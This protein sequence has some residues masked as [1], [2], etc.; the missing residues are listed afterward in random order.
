M[1]IEANISKG[2]TMTKP[3]HQAPTQRGSFGEICGSI[4]KSAYN[5][6]QNEPKINPIAGPSI[7]TPIVMAKK[8]KIS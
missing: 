3:N 6:V 4:D 5:R 7:L 1:A 8:I 2:D